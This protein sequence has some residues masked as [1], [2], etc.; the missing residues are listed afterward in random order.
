MSE[1]N[2]PS[3]AEGQ[4]ERARCEGGAAE[5]G[6]ILEL[7]IF[8]EPEEFWNQLWNQSFRCHV[9]SEFSPWKTGTRKIVLGI[10]DLSIYFP[11]NG[12]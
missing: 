9:G 7:L 8:P 10:L 6:G 1:R 5:E 4:G 11:E 3:S 2:N 12:L